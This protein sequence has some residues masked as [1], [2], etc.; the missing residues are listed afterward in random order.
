MP[1]NTTN[2]VLARMVKRGF[3][4]VMAK[5]TKKVNVDKQFEEVDKR[6]GIVDKRLSGLEAE[7][8][9]VNARLGVIEQDIAEI[10]R[11]FVYRDEFE[12]ALARILLLEK[13]V[14]I[15]SGK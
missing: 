13:K 10:R 6:L 11:H 9:H 15:K 5:M 7:T 4:D 12:D 8:S 14:G 1:K 2:E 3:D